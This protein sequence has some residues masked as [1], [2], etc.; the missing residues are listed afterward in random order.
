MAV[1]DPRPSQ[2]RR[3]VSESSHD[4]TV[5]NLP[6]AGRAEPGSWRVDDWG[7]DAALVRAAVR[8]GHLRWNVAIDGTRNLPARR[9]ALI[10]VSGRRYALAPIVTALAVGDATGRAV[11]FV[12]RP[13]VAPFGPLLRRLGGLLDRADEVRGAL[14]AGELVVIGTGDRRLVAAAIETG[15]RVFPARTTTS[16]W[17]RN[18]H[19]EI[20]PAVR[21]WCGVPEGAP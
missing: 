19:V 8:L 21:R 15:T 5:I 3:G 1:G 20:S 12:G 6:V 13:D 16:L 18:A 10:V 4:A 2:E 9:G 17:G 7:R 14:R 11:R